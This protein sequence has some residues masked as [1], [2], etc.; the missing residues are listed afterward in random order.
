M[1]MSQ[2]Q[3]NA[4]EVPSVNLYLVLSDNQNI[5]VS[6]VF[7]L[8]ATQSDE[9]FPSIYFICLCVC[10]FEQSDLMN[11]AGDQPFG[12]LSR[13]KVNKIVRSNKCHSIYTNK[14]TGKNKLLSLNCDFSTNVAKQ[15]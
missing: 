11:A 15:A 4:F 10:D 7:A 5:F 8:N 3:H 12:C 13:E 2:Q 9:I 6:A 1:K 14:L